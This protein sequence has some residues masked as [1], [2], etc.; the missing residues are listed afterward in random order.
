M[1][2]GIQLAKPLEGKRLLVKFK[3]GVEKVYD[4]SQLLHLEMFQSLKDDAFFRSVQVDA[5]G[6]G[7]SCNNKV[8]LSEYELWVNGEEPSLAR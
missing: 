4:C 7:I 8:D 5:G 3:N 1:T 2:P 6:Y